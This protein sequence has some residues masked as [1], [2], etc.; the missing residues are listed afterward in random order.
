VGTACKAS[1]ECDQ[2]HGVFCN[3]ITM[4]CDNVAFAGPNATCGLVN[5]GFVLCTG[6]GSLCKG[7]NAPTYQGTCV[8]YATDGTAC[9]PTNGPLCDVGAVCASGTC[10]IPDGTCQ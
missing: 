1:T 2:L 6:P 4:K 5:N 3:P 8:P 10:K 9:D 7:A